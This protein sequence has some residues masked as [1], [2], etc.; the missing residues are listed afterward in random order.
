[1]GD[2]TKKV[3][4]CG[5]INLHGNFFGHKFDISCAKEPAHTGCVGLGIERWVLA[6]F[7][8]HGLDPYR[9]PAEI[10]KKIF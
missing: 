1:M 3:L 10:R 5:S 2:G 4:A 7:S 6:C 8:Q 9:W